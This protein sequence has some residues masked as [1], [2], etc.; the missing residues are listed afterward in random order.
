MNFYFS[1]NEEFQR[2]VHNL[3]HYDQGRK[4][5]FITWRTA[6]SLPQSVLKNW[7][8]KK[9]SWL[10]KNPKPWNTSKKS[11]Y[12][13]HLMKHIDQWLDRGTGRC[14]LSGARCRKILV[15]SLEFYDGERYLLESFV[16]MPNHIHVLIS[17]NEGEKL[18]KVV[19]SWKRYSAREI[20]LLLGNEGRFW[21]P[22]YF[23]TVLRSQEH[24]WYVH[25][26]IKNNPR[27]L[28]KGHFTYWKKK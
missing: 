1:P 23:D 15:N 19:Q 4:Y 28:K 6:D 22:D 8:L 25:Q 26:Y 18:S 10:L 7:Q 14:L 3:P 16:I 27:H 2:T 24:L 13:E 12:R 17:L 20:N 5:Y 11:E 9:Q 21:Q